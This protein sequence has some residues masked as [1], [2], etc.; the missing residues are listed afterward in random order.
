MRVAWNNNEEK[1]EEVL[2]R[3]AGGLDLESGTG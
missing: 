1:R 2:R 3:D